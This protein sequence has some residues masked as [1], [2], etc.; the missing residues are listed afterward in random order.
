MVVQM[1]DRRI[2][3]PADVGEAEL[4]RIVADWLGENPDAVE[5]LHSTAE[6]VPYDLDAITTAGRYWVRGEA[7]TPSGARTFSFFVKH[8][9]SWSRSPLFAAIPPDFREIAEASVP[10]RTEPLIYRSDLGDRLP[11]GLTLPRAV[12]VFDLDE[13]SAAVWLEEVPTAPRIWTAEQLAH[14]AYLLGRLAASPA[15]RELAGIGGNSEGRPV[16]GYLEGRLSHQILPMLRG[17]E[18]WQHPLVASAF[19]PELRTRLLTAADRLPAYVE[20]I[21]RMPIGASHGDAC[22]N[23]ILVRPDS[24]ELV[25]ID[26]GFWMPQPLGFDLSQ[27]LLGDVQLGRCPASELY[28]NEN[29]CTAAYVD[30]LRVEGCDVDAAVVRRAHALLMLIFS[31]MSAI[32]VEHLAS[33]PTPE[34]QRITAERAAA[35][36]FMLDLVDSTA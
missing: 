23:N 22:T 12:A 19:D 24:D 14:A 6:V 18:V 13:K 34:L 33:P 8:V 20:E 10:W 2:L 25:L 26:F 21:E 35:A 15:V 29:L 31:G 27:L 17:D 11:P 16:R 9:Q 1:S 5:V 3:G 28:R 7:R 32:P 4:V 36:R 30:G